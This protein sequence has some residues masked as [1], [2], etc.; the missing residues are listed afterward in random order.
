LL[1]FQ[2]GIAVSGGERHEFWRPGKLPDQSNSSR[3]GSIKERKLKG[4]STIIYF[5]CHSF[6][7]GKLKESLRGHPQLFTSSSTRFK[8]K[9]L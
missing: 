7:A 3:G 8:L 5:L 1:H 4:T 2:P 6:Q 9:I